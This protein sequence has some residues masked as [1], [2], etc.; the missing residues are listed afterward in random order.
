MSNINGLV[1]NMVRDFDKV[2]KA[3]NWNRLSNDYNLMFLEQ[4]IKQFWVDTELT[5][6]KDIKIWDTK[7]SPQEQNTYRK[8]LG[9]LTMLDTEQG[10]EGMPLIALHTPDLQKKAVLSFMGAMEHIHAKSYSTIFTTIDTQENIDDTFEWVQQNPYLQHK[11][12]VISSYYNNIFK[13]DITKKEYYMALVA[14]VFLESYLFYSG[15]FY[16]LYL[17]G[18]GKM[19]ASG[20]II[21][22]IIRDEAIHSIFVGLIAQ[23]VYNEFT[24]DEQKELYEESIQLMEMLMKNEFSYTEELYSEIGLDVEVKNFL[25]YN[26]NKAL[27]NLGFDG[28]YE[29]IEINPIVYNGLSTETKTYDFFSNKGNGYQKGI[30]KE[31]TN[32]TFGKVNALIEKRELPIYK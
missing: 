6:S 2:V 16:P 12:N 23:E 3:V 1:K 7:L 8:V 10:S 32:E 25:K 18:Q 26:A 31:I 21:N 14:S 15:F 4:N 29:D 9:G 5:P 11:G 27:Q 24:E 30:V 17:A 22:L 28:I 13:K 20:E 19:I